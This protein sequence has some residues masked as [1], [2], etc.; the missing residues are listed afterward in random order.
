MKKVDLRKLIK[1]LLSDNAHN[2]TDSAHGYDKGYAEG[3]HDALVDVMLQVG[4]ETNESW[5]N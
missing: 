2:L 5:F 3:Y 1:K 4:I